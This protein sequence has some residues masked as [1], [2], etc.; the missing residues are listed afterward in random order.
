MAERYPRTSTQTCNVILERPEIGPPERRMVLAY[1]I[2]L[3]VRFVIK[4]YESGRCTASPRVIGARNVRAW[5]RV[6][7]RW[8]LTA[9]ENSGCFYQALESL[10][11]A[12][13]DNPRAASD[14]L[15]EV[16][17]NLSL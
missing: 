16:L 8:I 10:R 11:W 1:T 2:E 6:T 13:E 7:D 3:F 9:I 12:I 4:R 14:G 5:T 15:L 17:T